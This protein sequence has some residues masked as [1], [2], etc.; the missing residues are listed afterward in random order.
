MPDPVSF[1]TH[2]ASEEAQEAEE[3]AQAKQLRAKEKPQQPSIEQLQRENAKLRRQ[4]ADMKKKN[5]NMKRQSIG[6]GFGVYQSAI[7]NRGGSFFSFPAE[8][9]TTRYEDR[10]LNVGASIVESLSTNNKSKGFSQVNISTLD[11]GHENKEKDDSE[12]DFVDVE[13]NT[14]LASQASG[15]PAKDALEH[16]PIR[17]RAQKKD[18]TRSGFRMLANTREDHEVLVEPVTEG[19]F[20]VPPGTKMKI[21]LKWIHEAKTVLIIKRPNDPDSLEK[22]VLLATFLNSRG[23]RVILESKIRPEVESTKLT[24]GINNSMVV[25]HP[26]EDLNNTD[27][28]FIVCLGGDGTILFASQLFPDAIPPILSF[29]MGSL[30]FLTP[31]PV[32]TETLEEV[33]S[34]DR[35][36]TV[37]ARLAV[38][39]RRLDGTEIN[40]TCLNEVVAKHPTR[41]VSLDLFVGEQKI[42]VVYADGLIV[43]TPTGSTAYSLACGGS[44]L[45]PAIPGMVVTPIAPHTLSFRP[46][47][48]PDS[49]TI[50]LQIPETART[51][52]HLSFDGRGDIKLEKGERVIIR[53]SEYPIAS[54]CLQGESS[55]WFHTIKKSFLWNVRTEQREHQ[56]E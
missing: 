32:K 26:S 12:E 45:H 53:Q 23:V 2:T 34:K 21:K 55:D 56:V 49:S 16:L 27:I 9:A 40:F 44:M 50:T 37:R 13:Y 25:L 19:R 39:V 11:R 47:V 22:L 6:R 5:E 28:D 24:A 35:E 43:A 33:L 30:G 14:Y 54:Y 4:I 31:F 51:G 20:H 15:M 42:T 52:A 10:V 18:F 38:T 46:I 1:T 3:L 41:M 17:K 7:R 48:L 36:V 8:Q 29:R